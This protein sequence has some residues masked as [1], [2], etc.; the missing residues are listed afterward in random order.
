M[1]SPRWRVRGCRMKCRGLQ[2]AR[3]MGAGNQESL[4]E[5]GDGMTKT[6]ACWRDILQGTARDKE[7]HGL[8]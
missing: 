2:L 1:F 6:M 8:E 5:V 7:V 4:E 3:Q